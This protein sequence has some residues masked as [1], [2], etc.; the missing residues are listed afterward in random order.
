MT[1]HARAT[2]AGRITVASGF[3]L[4][5]EPPD[6]RDV[7]DLIEALD[8]HQKPLYPPE[9]H[10]GID[11]A[12]LSRPEVVF[13][14]AR[15]RTDTATGCGAVVIDATQGEIKRMFVRPAAR[16]CGLGAALLLR[17]EHEAAERGCT[18]MRLETGVRQP[19]AIGLYAR[20]GYRHRGPFGDYAEDPHSVF[21]EK[22][23]PAR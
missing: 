7:L 3:T 10:H 18:V 23:L 9:S 19:E 21:M 17:L 14:V 6:Q 16:G 8:A 22:A 13:V 20:G 2:D 4:A 12:A 5:V 1:A 11:I 15:D